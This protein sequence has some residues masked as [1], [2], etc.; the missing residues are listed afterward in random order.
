MT[1]MMMMMTM[2]TSEW[3]LGLSI[4]STWHGTPSSSVGKRAKWARCE[5]C[6]P[7]HSLREQSKGYYYVIGMLP[8]T[9][10][11]IE[12]YGGGVWVI[13]FTE[14]TGTIFS[15]SPGEQAAQQQVVDQGTEG[16]EWL[17]RAMI[18]YNYLTVEWPPQAWVSTVQ[19]TCMYM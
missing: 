14:W 19:C 8:Y 10:L 12:C 5:K 7:A 2:M 4:H 9:C 17:P 15:I 11:G 3:T 6:Q 1:T 13:Q 16:L 18:S